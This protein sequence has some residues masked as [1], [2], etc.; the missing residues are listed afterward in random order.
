RHTR[1]K[2]DW[3]S[4]V[5]SSDLDG[6][7][8]AEWSIGELFVYEAADRPWAPPPAAVA[9]LAEARQELAHYMDDPGG[10]NPRRAPVTAAH[11]RGQ[12]I[13]RASC[14]GRVGGGGGAG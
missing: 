6:P 14:R 10:P 13:G 5:C 7:W 4:D 12:E 9:V 3:S 11:R 8:G 2:R 1:S